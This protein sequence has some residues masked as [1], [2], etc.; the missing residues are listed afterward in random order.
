MPETTV[1]S[2]ARPAVVLGLTFLLVALTFALPFR[3]VP[4][5]ELSLMSG[6][7]SPEVANVYTC[8]AWAGWA[9]FLF[10]FRG[11]GSALARLD[12]ERRNGRLLAYAACLALT[13][14]ALLGAR[15]AVGPMLFGAIVWVYFIDHFLKA[16]QQF[17]GKGPT[18][19]PAWLRW[20]GSY[21][22]LIGFTW[23]SVVLL[24]IGG[25]NSHPWLLWSVSFALGLAVLLFGGWRSLVAG[26][27]RGPLLALFFV[28][29]ALVWG[30]FSRYGGPVF[31]TGV[32]VFH[33]AAGSY[34]HYLG[35]YF[36]AHARSAGRD[37]LVNPLA[38]LAI[39]VAVVALG[40][41]VATTEALRWLRPILGVPWFTLWVAV[42]LVTSDLFPAI[43]RWR[44]PT[45][46]AEMA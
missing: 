22:P 45:K 31:L 19:A 6:R 4:A 11:Q 42:H 35:S 40:Y 16:E 18:G 29:E 26:D 13:V 3:L 7:L 37:P 28:A 17:E 10:A 20:L 9:H 23:L 33:I 21:Q 1:P 43:K 38:I 14:A 36:V 15:E 5:S 34:F 30:T 44:S 12:D 25:V 8:V 41:A 39:N 24:D 46:S 32:Y 2:P 27:V